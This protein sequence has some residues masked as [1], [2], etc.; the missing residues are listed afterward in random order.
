MLYYMRRQGLFFSSCLH[1]VA[2]AVSP[3]AKSKVV[4]G[5][6]VAGSQQWFELVLLDASPG[7]DDSVREVTAVSE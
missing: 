6:P 7:K 2:K 3:V 4:W 5:S 1:S